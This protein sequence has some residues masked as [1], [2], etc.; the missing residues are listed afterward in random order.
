MSAF[1]KKNTKLIGRP[2]YNLKH[3]A[4]LV[5]KKPFTIVFKRFKTFDHKAGEYH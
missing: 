1:A 3:S 2:V 4:V 5:F